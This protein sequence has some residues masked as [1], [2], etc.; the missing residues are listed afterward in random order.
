[1]MLNIVLDL[2]TDSATAWS[3]SLVVIVGLGGFLAYLVL[4]GMLAKRLSVHDIL[5]DGA[6]RER[7]QFG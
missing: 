7:A 2:D 6:S 1:M 4:S 5:V 3:G